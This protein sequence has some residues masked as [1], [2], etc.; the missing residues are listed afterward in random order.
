MP[1]TII[2]PRELDVSNARQFLVLVR[3]TIGAEVHVRFE[4]CGVDRI[5]GAGAQLLLALATAL[6][7]VGGGIEV[8]GLPDEPRRL[9]ALA[10]LARLTRDAE[11]GP[12]EPSSP[13]AE[14]ENRDA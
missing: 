13:I 11:K 2:L 8:V 9:L 14:T 1:A 5:D 3:Q 7:A 12:S 4:G 10:G 6:E